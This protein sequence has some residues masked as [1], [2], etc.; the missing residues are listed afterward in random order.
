MHDTGKVLGYHLLLPIGCVKLGEKFAFCSILQAGQ[1]NKRARVLRQNL[2]RG[3]SYAGSR[4][5]CLRSKRQ[6]MS[7][8]NLWTFP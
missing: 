1:R 7:R 8:N 6:K 4:P 5:V 3:L 2:A